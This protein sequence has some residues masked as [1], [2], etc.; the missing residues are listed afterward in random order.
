MR[1]SRNCRHGGISA[2]RR[3]FG[4]FGEDGDAD[5]GGLAGEPGDEF[6][7]GGDADDVFAGFVGQA[8]EAGKGVAVAGKGGATDTAQPQA[9][10]V[11]STLPADAC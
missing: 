9:D 1:Q 10:A 11:R 7:Q 4:L 5:D 2:G 6:G 3:G 8:E